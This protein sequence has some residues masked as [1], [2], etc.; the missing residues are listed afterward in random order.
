MGHRASYA[1]I[2]H[3]VRS[4]YYSH[5]GA[6][7]IP[8]QLLAGPE[9]TVGYLRTLAPAEKL[10]DS[11]WAEGAILL[12]VDQRRVYFWG[13]EDIAYYPYLRRVLLPA[14]RQLWPEWTMEW[15]T[16]GM[17][18]IARHMG[19]DVSLVLTD[20]FS[21]DLLYPLYIDDLREPNPGYLHTLITVRDARGHV[22]DYLFDRTF[23]PSAG[24]D[25]IDL[26]RGRAADRLPHECTEIEAGAYIDVPARELWVWEN[27]TL[28]PRYLDDLAQRWAGWQIYGHV[29]GIVRQTMLSGRSAV[30]IMMPEAEAVQEL[31]TELTHSLGDWF[32]PEKLLPMLTSNPP[33][34]TDR[35]EI[36]PGFLRTDGPAVSVEE[37]RQILQQLFRTSTTSADEG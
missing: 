32:D 8:A 29:E 10:L 9:R 11:A 13:G 3:G 7:G 15:A 4:M 19:L 26:C 37:R 31:I 2:E 22:A 24:P 20:P 25:L 35:I 14:L 6:K 27:E 12:D 36:Q 1:L 34:G 33:P 17:A 30:D 21:E 16:F 23:A 5:W 18:D 28:D